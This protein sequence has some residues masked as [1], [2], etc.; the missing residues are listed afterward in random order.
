MANNTIKK[1]VTKASD[2]IPNAYDL[3]I[4]ELTTL[5]ESSQRSII[6][7]LIMAYDDGFVR[8]TRAKARGKV[9]IL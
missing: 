5:Y 8:G 9:T 7:A 6:Q 4:E 1:T 2:G 3:S